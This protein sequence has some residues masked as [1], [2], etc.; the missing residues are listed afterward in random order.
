MVSRHSVGEWTGA[1]KKALQ[2]G[3]EGFPDAGFVGVGRTMA[4]G[5]GGAVIRPMLPDVRHQGCVVR[6]VFYRREQNDRRL[7]IRVR[8][9]EEHDVGVEIVEAFGGV[10]ALRDLVSCAQARTA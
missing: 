6:S 2:L 3:V 10:R 8:A 9:F 7:A 5:A 4:L 1:G